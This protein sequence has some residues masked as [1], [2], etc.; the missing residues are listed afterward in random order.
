MKIYK[1]FIIIFPLPDH[2]DHKIRSHMDMLAQETHEHPLY[3]KMIPHISLHRPLVNISFEKVKNLT[4]SIALKLHKGR[5]RIGG[6]D[7]FGKEY[8]VVPVHATRTIAS[9]W[10][11]VHETFSQLPE[12]EHGPFDHDNT[13]HITLAENFSHFYDQYWE[14]IK[15]SCGV[16]AEDVEIDRIAVYGKSDEGWEKVYEKHLPDREEGSPVQ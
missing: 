6:V 3:L 10:S 14:K 12:Y 4:E 8:I 13:L 15:A 7:H 16:D 5:I 11:T 2:Y 1:K 9:L